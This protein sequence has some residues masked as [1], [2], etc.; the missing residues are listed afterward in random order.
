MVMEVSLG[1]FAMTNSIGDSLD[2][3]ILFAAIRA[4]PFAWFLCLIVPFFASLPVSVPLW[5]YKPTTT[6]GWLAEQTITALVVAYTIP[7][8]MHL[9]G[10]A[11]RRSTDAIERRQASVMSVLVEGQ[12]R[13]R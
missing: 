3:G 4:Q 10:Q 12:P 5:F 13:F 2:L 11:Y 7:V 8:G 6:L 9:I 1:R